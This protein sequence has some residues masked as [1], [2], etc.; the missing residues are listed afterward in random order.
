[1]DF[2]SAQFNHELPCQT[3]VLNLKTSVKEKV[4]SGFSPRVVE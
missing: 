4:E 1:M 2:L 3:V